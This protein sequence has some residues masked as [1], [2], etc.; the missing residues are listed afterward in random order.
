MKIKFFIFLLCLTSFNFI[1]LSQEQTF[2]PGVIGGIVTSQVGGDGYTGFNKLGFSFG[3][4]VRYN[5]NDK[6]SMQF[7]IAYVQKGSRNDFSISENDPAQAAEYFI[8]R[9]DYIEL[10][11]LFKFS[12]RNFVYEAGLYYGRLVGFYTEYYSGYSTAGPYESLD[13]FNEV[14]QDLGVT[15]VF[16]NYD[17]GILI[18]AGYKIT[19]NL[20]GSVRLSNSL[21]AIWPFESGQVDYYPTSFRI[22][23][24]NTALVGTLRYTFGTGDEIK[25]L[26][27]SSVE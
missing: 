13:D 2:K 8:L 9:L 16:K 11:L 6:W 21:I 10:P 3:G 1:L 24:T 7:E 26:K 15:A 27:K 4:Y 20:L 12:H 22:G 5:L 23:Y 19:D 18:G 25:Y 14:L 17:F